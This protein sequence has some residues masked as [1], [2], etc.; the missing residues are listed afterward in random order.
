ML[1]LSPSEQTKKLMLQNVKESEDRLEYLIGQLRSMKM[2]GKMAPEQEHLPFEHLLVNSV[3]NAHKISYRLSSINLKLAKEKELRSKTGQSVELE[4][5]K[6]TK[7]KEQLLQRAKNRY[8]ALVVDEVEHAPLEHIEFN[9]LFRMSLVGC[10]NVSITGEHQ[11]MEVALLIDGMLRYK[12]QRTRGVWNEHFEIELNNAKEME[13]KILDDRSAILAMTWFPIESLRQYQEKKQPREIHLDL[14]PSGQLTI[15]PLLI[16]IDEVKQPGVMRRDRG[17][18]AKVFPRNGH[19]FVEQEI[20]QLHMCAFCNEAME[21]SQYKCKGCQYAIHPKCYHRVITTCVP[22]D[23]MQEQK[24]TGMLLKYKI[25]H[26]WENVTNLSTAYCGH[27]A[28]KMSGFQKL[29]CLDCHKHSHK[30]CAPMIPNFCGLTPENADILVAAFEEHERKLLQKQIQEAEASRV[31]TFMEMTQQSM[32]ELAQEEPG[33][34]N[35]DTLVDLG[36]MGEIGKSLTNHGSIQ[37]RTTKFKAA[38]ELKIEDFHFI[39]VLGRGAYGKVM[40]AKEK[41]TNKTYAIKA[42]KKQSLKSGEIVAMMVEKDL[43]LENTL[44]GDD[45][46]IKLADYGICKKDMRFGETTATFVG[47]PDYMAPEILANKRYDKSVD[48]YSLGVLLYV[49]LHGNYPYSHNSDGELLRMILR[50]QIKFS[51]KIG[52]VTLSLMRAVFQLTTAHEQESTPETWIWRVRC[53]GNQM[54]SILCKH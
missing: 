26:R 32:Q 47:T 9:G 43:K 19:L 21:G 7:D 34:E 11:E 28:Q 25:P 52:R 31:G 14:E 3:L 50:D 29:R 6:S 20:A 41:V 23:K 44:V 54:P 40:L 5:A 2:T 51:P 4:R 8:Q 42:L 10:A 38:R 37:R 1:M 39:A 16:S 33:L 53:G 36:L 15:Y 35:S 46:H 27:C 24:N 22:T 13:I 12:S 45:G 49:M 18:V 48:W 17:V 30:E